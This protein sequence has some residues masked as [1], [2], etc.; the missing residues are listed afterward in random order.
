MTTARQFVPTNASLAKNWAASVILIFDIVFIV[1]LLLNWRWYEVAVS[2][3]N[4]SYFKLADES[5]KKWFN[6][7]G[8]K[9]HWRTILMYKR[10]T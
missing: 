1:L 3:E 5:N 9:Q 2:R 4:E 6:K 10:R 7:S 8:D